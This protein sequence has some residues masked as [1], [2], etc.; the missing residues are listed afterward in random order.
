[1]PIRSRQRGY[2]LTEIL[3]VI[4]IIVLVLALAVPAFNVLNGNRSVSAAENQLSAM[5]GRARQLALY[6]GREVGLV[7]YE[8]PAS[9]RSA[10]ALVWVT[11]TVG[12]T[13]YQLE[14]VPDQDPV[15]LQAGVGVR[16]VLGV[17][18]YRFPTLVMF[19]PQGT[20]Y[21]GGN[22][23]RFTLESVDHDMTCVPVLVLHDREAYASV[24]DPT[25]WLQENGL[26]LTINRYN[27]TFLPND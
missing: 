13:H 26:F 20:L 2:T 18:T 5:L 15:L 27:G 10:A 14:L 21:V 6:Y 3:V 25:T 24:P 19:T 9:T 8:D 7:F 16:G 11:S 12:P 17:N 4:G 22:T 1:M 23:Y